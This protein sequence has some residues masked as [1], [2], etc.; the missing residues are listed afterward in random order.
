M[1]YIPIAIAGSCHFKEKDKESHKA[2]KRNL[3]YI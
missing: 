1:M 2:K 3:L